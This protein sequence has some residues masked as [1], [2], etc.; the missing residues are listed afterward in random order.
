MPDQ[1]AVFTQVRSAWLGEGPSS[2]IVVSSRIRLARNL[3]DLP[4]PPA[5]GKDALQ[6][7]LA[8]ARRAAGHLPEARRYQVLE[9]ARLSPLER[10]V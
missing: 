4:F 8:R 10:Q 5:A 3:A 7:V 1:E 2:D 9:L 6:E